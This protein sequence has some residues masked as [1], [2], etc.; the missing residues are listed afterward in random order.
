MKCTIVVCL[1]TH[2]KI[3]LIPGRKQSGDE[4]NSK[5]KEIL[6]LYLFLTSSH[7]LTFREVKPHARFL[8]ARSESVT[9]RSQTDPVSCPGNSPQVRWIQVLFRYYMAPC[10]GQG[11]FPFYRGLRPSLAIPLFF[12]GECFRRRYVTQFWP[13]KPEGQFAMGFLEKNFLLTKRCTWGRTPFLP[14]CDCGFLRRW[15]LIA[16]AAI[17]KSWGES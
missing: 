7:S 13:V 16:I 5:R 1:F 17:L 9:L 8:S 14:V 15:C 3:K 6:V 12:A 2:L 10:S 11:V 4:S